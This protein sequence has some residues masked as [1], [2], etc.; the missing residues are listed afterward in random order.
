MQVGGTSALRC[1]PVS[2][3]DR[4]AAAAARNLDLP[5]RA[6]RK[7]TRIYVL[8]FSGPLG[9][10]IWMGRRYTQSSESGRLRRY[11]LMLGAVWILVVGVS[12][13]FDVYYLREATREMALQS[14]LAHFNKDQAFRFWATAHG[15]VYVPAGEKTSPNPHLSHLPERDITLPSGKRLTLMN[16]AYMLRQMQEEFAQLYEVCGRITSLRPLRPENQ[17]DPWE[18]S[19]LEAFE[20]G[21]QEVVEFSSIEGEP[22]LRLIRPIST[23]EGCLKCHAV[24]GYKV[25]DVRGGVGVALPM[26]P[27]LVRESRQTVR[28]SVTHGIMLTL[29]LAG[30]FLG[31]SRLQKGVVERE[32]GRRELERYNA[33]LE[34][35][36]QQLQDFTSMASHDLQ[37]PLRKIQVFGTLLEEECENRLRGHERDYLHRMKDATARMRS[38]IESL[39]NY[40]RISS[41]AVE[42]SA[43]DLNEVVHEAFSMLW[44]AAQDKKAT[45]KVDPLPMAHAA[46]QLM[47]QLFQN[48]IGNA[49]KYCKEKPSI[50]VWAGKRGDHVEIFVSDNGIG[51]AE[52]YTERIFAP[53]ERLH[54]RS[55]YEGTGMGLAICKKIVAGH[56]GDIGVRSTPGKGSV[57]SV[58]LP[59]Y[60][61]KPA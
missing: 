32:T 8:A 45:I 3:G 4:L 27:F 11:T 26:T 38:M 7:N 53:F 33:L 24:Q 28:L 6:F 15:G 20:S 49:I 46:R 30:I 18:R 14:A 60:R 42:R 37:E 35:K 58:T 54:G 52:E 2:M 55:E 40:S 12:F 22:F 36:N 44:A 17:P 47:V 1:D 61:G 43:V 21:V 48:L 59:L 31:Y 34:T 9:I 13:I 25:G 50:H 51:I 39:L 29:G 16:P 41:Q 57:F 23:Q 5:Y 56:G 19:A 10:L